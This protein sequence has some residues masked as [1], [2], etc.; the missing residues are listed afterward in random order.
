VDSDWVEG[1]L[2]WLQEGIEGL[3]ERCA[4][5]IDWLRGEIKWLSARVRALEDA[6]P[7]EPEGQ[8]TQLEALEA[9]VARLEADNAALKA[10]LQLERDE[11]LAYKFSAD[12]WMKVAI[13]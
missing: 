13:G 10:Q 1:K 5:D 2:E 4:K 9:A 6:Q 12:A 7:S 8:E 11:K 3:D